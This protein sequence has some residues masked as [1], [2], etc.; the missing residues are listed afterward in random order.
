MKKIK[1]LI[2][3]L[4]L[5]GIVMTGIALY[6]TVA[7]PFSAQHSKDT[8]TLSASS[9][10][11][12]EVKGQV[13]SV[14]NSDVISGN[15]SHIGH[16]SMTVKVTSGAYKDQVFDANNTLLG[17]VDMDILY[18]QG[19]QCLLAIQR[20][21][22]KVVS[23]KPLELNREFWLLMMIA[24][25]V[26]VLLIYSGWMGVRAILSFI[27]SVWILW[28]VFIKGL[29]KGLSPMP[30]TA[31]TVALLSAVIIFL[32]AG[33]TRKAL[34]AFL[35]TLAGLL[36]TLLL[37]LFFGHKLELYGLTQAYVQTLVISGY[38]NLN[39]QEIF[40][41]AVVLG[42]SGAAMDIAMDIC[43][44]MGELKDK[45]P[46]IET[47]TLIASGINVGKHVIGTMS[48]TL[49]LAYSGSFLTLL[50]LFQVKN[51]S[52]TRMINLKMVMAEV[53][54]TLIGSTGLVL[55][56]PLTALIGGLILNAGNHKLT[57]SNHQ[58]DH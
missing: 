46:D 7:V 34:A 23:V 58:K 32:V 28:E 39:I 6:Y 15:L 30:L 8:E 14:D 35:S 57:Q 38:F 10:E 29:L 48:T 45:K 4:L 17:Q 5:V 11:T 3:P 1:S 16:Q 24:F 44:S 18:R 22:G 20:Q 41:A 37:T 47:A 19:D 9:S 55:V 49:L 50:M 21:E 13:L 31:L 36:I 26:A 51:T 25:F 42:A 54:R 40:F 52:L 43:A 53:M 56:A 12:L 27:L 2:K 33:L